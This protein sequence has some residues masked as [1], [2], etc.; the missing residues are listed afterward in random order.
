MPPDTPLNRS[1]EKSFELNHKREKLKIIANPKP[2]IHI[3]IVSDQ[4]VGHAIL[5]SDSYGRIGLTKFH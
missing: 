3:T 1:K 4:D 2:T 5:N